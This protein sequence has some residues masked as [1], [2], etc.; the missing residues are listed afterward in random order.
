MPPFLLSVLLNKYTLGALAVALAVGAYF[1]WLAEHDAK[2]RAEDAARVAATTA[3][4]QVRQAQEGAAAVQADA[5]ESIQRAREVNNVKLEIARAPVSVGCVGSPAVLRA[6]DSLR[7]PGAGGG[8]A[9]D[10]AG[11]VVV[12]AGTGTARR[13]P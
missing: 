9:G 12:P 5:A 4:E 1:V 10:P 8:P 2:L 11:P 7:H 13:A 6:L 3:A